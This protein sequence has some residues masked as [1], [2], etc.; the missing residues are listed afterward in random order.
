MIAL[1]QADLAHIP[2]VLRF[3]KDFYKI[4]GD[5]Y[6][7]ERN[8]KNLKLL[9]G[10]PEL[11]R[12]FIVRNNEEEIGYLA[13]TFGFSFEYGGRD[14]FIDEFYLVENHRGQ[15]IGKKVFELLDPLAKAAGVHTLHLEVE[16]HNSVAY[17][18]YTHAGFK[19]NNRILMNKPLI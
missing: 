14:A 6:N 7:E 9:I 12:L 8:K 4:D 16:R 17:K 5:P 2:K 11:G 15:G 10:N 18:L 1:T 3:M 19:E 13:L